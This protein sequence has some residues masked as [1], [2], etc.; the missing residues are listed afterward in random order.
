MKLIYTILTALCVVLNVNADSF[1]DWE[2]RSSNKRI[3]AKV[4]DIHEGK[5][6]LILKT[7][8]KGYWVKVDDLSDVDQEYL[9]TWVPHENRMTIRPYQILITK[10]NEPQI[11]KIKS[12]IG[13]A[14][15]RQ[16]EIPAIT[17]IGLVKP[18]VSVNLE[19]NEY[20]TGTFE[21]Y[22][23]EG[24]LIDTKIQKGNGG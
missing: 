20:A 23:C 18:I 8:K 3:H 13:E 19:E 4:I 7:T 24:S 14:A 11:L 12:K 22:S 15:P 1:R 6:H 17:K 21:L 10:S 16:I 9:K 5:A 2:S